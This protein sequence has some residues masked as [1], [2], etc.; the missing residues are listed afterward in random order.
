[1]ESDA[2]IRRRD[3]VVGFTEHCIKVVEGK[4]LGQQLVTQLVA[5]NDAV[6]LLRKQKHKIKD[7]ITVY[8]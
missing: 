4:V 2:A 1:V 3:I 6:Q 5:F 7:G 8:T